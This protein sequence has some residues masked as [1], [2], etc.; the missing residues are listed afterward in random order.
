MQGLAKSLFAKKFPGNPWQ[1]KPWEFSFEKVDYFFAKTLLPQGDS[2]VFAFL[3]YLFSTARDG[4][5]YATVCETQVFPEPPP[6]CKEAIMAGATKLPCELLGSVII[7]E[8]NRWYLKR[9]YDCE[10]SLLSCL[11]KIK[12]R[13]VSTSFSLEVINH[14][15]EKKGLT[16]EQREAIKKALFSPLTFIC[17]GPGTGKTRTAVELISCFVELSDKKIAVASPTGK[18]SANIRAFLDKF[19]NRCEVFTLHSL[20]QASFLPY[21][22]IIID[23]SSMIDA[24]LMLNLLS[25]VK[26]QLV[27]LGDIDQ[28]PPVGVGNCFHDFVKREK[29]SVIF[30]T[31]CLRAELQEIIDL[32]HK[33]RTKQKVNIQELPSKEELLELFFSKRKT[34][35][36]AYFHSFRILAPQRKGLY[37][38][39]TLNMMF[40]EEAKKRGDHLIPIIIKVNDRKLDLYNGDFGFLDEKEG[41]G[42][43]ENGK[44]FSSSLLPAFEYGY[45]LSIHKS[46]GSEYE[47]VVVLLSEGAEHF[48]KEMLYTA[49]TRARKKVALFGEEGIL[50]KIYA[51]EASRNSIA[52]N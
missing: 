16:E 4:H 7:S 30:L 10:K 26:E 5:L 17:G 21:D 14:H 36:F 37:G 1:E 6:S 20:L 9:N 18:A 29:D 34:N 51:K 45:V 13:E 35:D 49:V 42:F 48:G 52:P 28:L 44:Q 27:F 25:T 19:Q 38:V 12:T 15:L 50:E 31:K 40:Y 43:F 47:E 2:D 11:D 32:S 3:A 8:D 23:E 22:L 46:Q 33:V 39:D 41:V 24:F